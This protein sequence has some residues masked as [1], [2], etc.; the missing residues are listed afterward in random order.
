MGYYK[1]DNTFEELQQIAKIVE[2]FNDQQ[3]NDVFSQVRELRYRTE[4]AKE[5]CE[6]NGY[7]FA[8]MNSM[9]G[10]AYHKEDNAVY[11][12]FIGEYDMDNGWTKKVV[13]E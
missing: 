3:M 9:K 4:Q 1:P 11:S 7:T 12:A 8:W 6:A 13:E 5:I 10:F 2:R